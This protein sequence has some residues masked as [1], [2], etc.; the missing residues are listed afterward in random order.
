MIATIRSYGNSVY[1]MDTLHIKLCGTWFEHVRTC[2]APVQT[3]SVD[4][5]DLQ[6]TDN[7]AVNQNHLCTFKKTKHAQVLFLK[8]LIQQ[9]WDLGMNILFIYLFIYF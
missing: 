9:S 5:N 6:I 4:T 1:E 8:M 3:S 7:L 2:H